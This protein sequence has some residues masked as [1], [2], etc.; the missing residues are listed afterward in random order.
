MQSLSA[1]G[2][3]KPLSHS[4]LTLLNFIVCCEVFVFR[5]YNFVCLLFKILYYLFLFLI[6]LLSG[7][8]E[9]DP[10]PKSLYNIRRLYN[11]IKN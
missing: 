3:Q 7:D 2:L 11:I 6:L 8:F 5:I 9:E 1:R 10:D 4:I